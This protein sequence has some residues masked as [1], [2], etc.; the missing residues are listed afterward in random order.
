MMRLLSFAALVA[1]AVAARRRRQQTFTDM[2]N[3]LIEGQDNNPP[4]GVFLKVA[5]VPLAR[6]QSGSISVDVEDITDLFQGPMTCPESM[7]TGAA[8]IT[9][10]P[11][12][13]TCTITTQFQDK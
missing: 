12:Q 1:V 9:V 6:D 13:S 2:V 3:P 7:M 8:R 4:T 11:S 5:S 10:Q